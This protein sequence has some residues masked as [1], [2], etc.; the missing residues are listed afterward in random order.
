MARKKST[1]ANNI[2]LPARTFFV[3]IHNKCLENMGFGGFDENTVEELQHK[4]EEH[5]KNVLPRGTKI[6]STICISE[7][8]LLHVHIVVTFSGTK[9]ITGVKEYFGNAHCEIML[10]TKTDAIMYINKEGK[11]EEKGEKILAKF[12]EC[13]AIENNAGTRSDLAEFDKLVMSDNFDLNKFLLTKRNEKD[14]KMYTNRFYRLKEVENRKLRDI[15]V[16]YIEGAPGSGKSFHVYNNNDFS[17]IFKI[18]CDEKANFPFDGYACQPIL[19]LDELRPGLINVAYLLQILD[20][21]PLSV[22]VKGSKAPACW[23]KVYITSAVPLSEWFQNKNGYEFSDDL[24]KQF[25]RRIT[26]HYKCIHNDEGYKIT[27][28]MTEEEARELLRKNNIK[29]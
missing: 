14:I 24:K 12:G 8:E 10:G 19:W 29:L 20:K 2:N 7:K 11:F 15:E 18:N 25:N 26:S 27:K 28:C 6:Y 17:Q 9:R 1:M 21:Y 22:N 23:T 3:V 4:L 13:D 16:I 5:Y